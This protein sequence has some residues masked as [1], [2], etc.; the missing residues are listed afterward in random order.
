MAD[1]Y[2]R[3]DGV[4]SHANKFIKL[5]PRWKPYNPEN[6]SGDPAKQE[7][8]DLDLDEASKE[9]L[10]EYAKT[11]YGV[12]LDKRKTLENLRQQVK[13]LVGA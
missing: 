13:E 9:Q 10:A 1:L 12:S 6:P 11:F 8:I 2:I 3:D 4:I 7:L 5:D